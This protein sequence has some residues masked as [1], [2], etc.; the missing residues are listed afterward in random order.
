M[1]VVLRSS[2]KPR[3]VFLVYSTSHMVVVE[4]ASFARIVR[5]SPGDVSAFVACCRGATEGLAVRAV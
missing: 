4:D 3:L 1:I 2:E 5:S